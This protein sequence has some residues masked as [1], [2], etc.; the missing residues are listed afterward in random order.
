MKFKFLKTAL[1]GVT[2]STACLV[3]IANAGVIFTNNSVVTNVQNNA[4]FDSLVHTDSRFD[5]SSYSEDGINIFTN[6]TAFVGIGLFYNQNNTEYYYG[7]G[8]NDEWVDISLTNGDLI[9]AMD[10]LLG[11]GIS[12]R[13]ANLQW[14]AYSG[15][16]LIDSNIEFNIDKGSTVGFSSNTGFSS[17]RVAAH[18]SNNSPGFGNAQSIAIDDLNIGSSVSVPEPSTLAILGLGILG[19]AS[20]RFT[21]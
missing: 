1:A 15:D 19:F 5:L 7:S 9:Y 16:T 4:T 17:I 18:G 2:L 13:T 6:D 21:K 10:F 20:R 14:K 3:N 11:E 12:S 8:G